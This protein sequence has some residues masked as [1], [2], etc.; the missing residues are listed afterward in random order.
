MRGWI[1]GG[2]AAGVLVLLAGVPWGEDAPSET[3]REEAAQRSEASFEGLARRSPPQPRPRTRLA[4]RGTVVD[5]LGRPVAG[6]RVSASWPEQGETL[7]TIPCPPGDVPSWARLD[8][9]PTS[10]WLLDECLPRT[11]DTL[12]SLLLARLGEAPVHAETRSAEDGSYVL[13][14][15]PEGHQALLALSE[16]GAVSRTGVSAGSQDVELMLEPP[17]FIQGQVL[18]EGD[19]PLAGVSLTVVSTRHTRFFDARTDVRGEFKLGPIPHDTYL[20]LASKEGWRPTL[21]HTRAPADPLEVRLHRSH[22]L[23]GWVVSGDVSV[24]GVEVLAVPT[25]AST[26]EPRPFRVTTDS[27][28]YFELEVSAGPYLLTAKREGRSALTR[29]TVDT[30]RPSEVVLKLGDA[31]QV[32]G[33]VLA[34]GSEG[35][36]AGARVRLQSRELRWRTL[37]TTTNEAGRYRV[38]PVEPGEWM[39]SIDSPGH[40][41]MTG[42]ERTLTSDQGTHDFFLRRATS[43]S[44]HVVDAAGQPVGDVAL[45]LK[46]LDDADHELHDESRTTPDGSFMLDVSSPGEFQVTARSHR[47]LETSVTA[48]APMTDLR[49][50]LSAGGVVEGTLTDS[51]GLPLSG[52]AVSV[53]PENGVGATASPSTPETNPHGQFSLGG[54]PS[55][56]YRVQAEQVTHRVERMVWALVEVHEGSISKVD[57]QLPAEHA[58]EGRIVDTSG[59]PIQGASIQA[60]PRENEEVEVITRGYGVRAP[61]KVFSDATGNF[62]LQGLRDTDHLVNAV[63]E[64]HGLLPEYSTEGIPSQGGILVG[65]EVKQLRLVMKRYAHVRGRL[66]GPTG[67]PVRKFQADNTW[68]TSPD[69]SFC[70]PKPDGPR[71]R[72]VFHAEGMLK[73]AR[74]VQG[75]REGPDDDL[76]EIRLEAGRELRGVVRDARTGEPLS[77]VRV[78]LD[79]ERPGDGTDYELGRQETSDWQGHFILRSVPLRPLTLRSSVQQDTH[80][81][82]RTQVDSTQQEVTV[83]MSGVAPERD[84]SPREEVP[85]ESASLDSP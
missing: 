20:L 53:T 30:T 83:W 25:E 15:L 48:R 14:D 45:Y 76:G 28:G 43:I 18:G 61:S 6:A 24:E 8:E 65:T 27:G 3:R 81:E 1:V 82:Q 39:F 75:G 29:V 22:R 71:E 4:I 33:S 67:A 68:V 57:L 5:G 47:F 38:G 11:E 66:V 56:R 44:G 46:R 17:T 70:V 52:F 40:I 55:G 78:S 63:L 21:Q 31:L 41:D 60:W 36:V 84:T 62:V 19:A 69:G 37:E 51:R 13:E 32:E 80:L 58:L 85:Q 59:R 73:V 35:P 26:S 42:D 77:N 72:L 2:I 16:H 74:V 34:V 50:T 79:G 54:I 7:S 23:S 64:G 12:V 10:P 9:E 49:I